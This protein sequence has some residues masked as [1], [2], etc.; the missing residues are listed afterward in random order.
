[1]QKTTQNALFVGLLL[2]AG[3]VSFQGIFTALGYGASAEGLSRSIAGLTGSSQ[4]A[5]VELATSQ[6]AAHT[7]PDKAQK[8][9]YNCDDKVDYDDFTIFQR[10]FKRDETSL[11]PY[12]EWVR[13]FVFDTVP[14]TN[15]SSSPVPSASTSPAPSTSVSP[16]VSP[17]PSTDVSAH[18][19]AAISK[20]EESS[21]KA[22]LESIVDNDTIPGTDA[23]QTRYSGTSGHQTEADYAKKFFDNL[24]IQSEF[25]PFTFTSRTG[26]QIS[27]KNL[28]ARLPGTDTSNIYIA[29]AHLDSISNEDKK[30]RAPGADD[31]GSGTT[32]VM[33]MA[34]AIKQSGVPLNRSIEFI[35]FSGEE[36]GLNGSY[37]Y[38]DQIPAGKKVIAALNFDMIGNRGTEPDCVNVY[39]QTRSG[40]NLI[41]DTMMDIN[42][43]F[44]IG[45]T[46]K[47]LASS[48]QDSDHYAFWRKRMTAT[49]AHECA[50][51]PVYHTVNDKPD[52]IS[53][54]Q[55]TK[56]AKVATGTLVKMSHEGQGQQLQLA[57]NDVLAAETSLNEDPLQQAQTQ[58][59]PIL[60]YVEYSQPQDLNTLHDIASNFIAFIEESELETPIFVGMFTSDEVK[61]AEETGFTV[62]ILD[63]NADL[64]QYEYLYHPKTGQS[65]LLTSFGKVTEITPGYYLLK[66]SPGKVFDHSGRASQFFHMPLP[67]NESLPEFTEARITLAPT[68]AVARPTIAAKGGYTEVAKKTTLPLLLLIGIVVAS[69]VGYLSMRR[70]KKPTDSN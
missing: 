48:R 59:A 33:E 39:Y 36:D 31:N 53:Y 26:E 37:Y 21:I 29:M 57:S 66:L 32:A 45:L 49:F 60:A 23:T 61:K 30:N 34:K 13:H 51:S 43:T 9:D 63:K 38:V 28:I 54:S 35:L 14:T 44:N 5:P 58:T 20:V 70:I 12:Y 6:Y 68:Q 1:M 56:M 2:F 46:T 10:D 18:I 40:G 65:G 55:I 25:Q 16:S 7:C 52:K 69:I 50:F 41:T 47:P 64:N 3:V 22:N 11:S 17:V 15:P 19:Q 8:G 67:L 42:K 27:T 24:G 62:N 4:N